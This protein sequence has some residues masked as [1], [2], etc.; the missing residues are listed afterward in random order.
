[1]S[2]ARKTMDAV[3]YESMYNVLNVLM[4]Q[5]DLSLEL[6]STLDLAELTSLVLQQVTYTSHIQAT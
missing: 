6:R 5:R 3:P 4:K 1:M 2:D